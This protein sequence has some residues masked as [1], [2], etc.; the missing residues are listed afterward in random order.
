MIYLLNGPFFT[1]SS[2]STIHQNL[3]FDHIFVVNFLYF[4]WF[5]NTEVPLFGLCSGVPKIHF[6]LGDEPKS[7]MKLWRCQKIP[8]IVRTRAGSWVGSLEKRSFQS[9]I[10]RVF[11]LFLVLRNLQ[12]ALWGIRDSNRYLWGFEEVCTWPMGPTAWQLVLLES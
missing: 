2:D 3:G 8:W 7:R 12:P 11:F 4:L 1:R 5:P 6:P 10:F 9:R